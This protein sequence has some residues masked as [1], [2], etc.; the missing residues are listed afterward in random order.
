MSTFGAITSG[1]YAAA[2]A[3]NAAF[4][5]L[6]HVAQQMATLQRINRASD[7]PAGMVAASEL[8]AD[9]I[10]LQHTPDA[11][12][13]AIIQATAALSDVRDADFTGLVS[14]LIKA[15]I[16]AKVSIFAFKAQLQSMSLIGLLFDSRG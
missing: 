9:L 4:A 8:E 14:D 6:D 15:Q 10:T 2:N 3:V 12:P 7:D 16:G 1:T 5:R 13:E 11:S